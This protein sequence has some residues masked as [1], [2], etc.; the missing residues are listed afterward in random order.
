MFG[1]SLGPELQEVFV[2]TV[3]M[4]LELAIQCHFLAFTYKAPEMT[5]AWR[6]PKHAQNEANTMEL[7]AHRDIR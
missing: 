5:H 1:T 3:W 6:S 7:T 2:P 4:N